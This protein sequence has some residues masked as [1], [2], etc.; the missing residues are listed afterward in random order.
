M[1]HYHELLVFLQIDITYTMY[2]HDAD[3]AN[4]F[5]RNQY[6]NNGIKLKL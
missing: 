2:K 4:L 5:C 1:L 3:D 6:I